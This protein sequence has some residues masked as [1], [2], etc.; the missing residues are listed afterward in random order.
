[1]DK[2]RYAK[3]EWLV[4][5]RNV[6]TGSTYDVTRMASRIELKSEWM[7]GAPGTLEMQLVAMPGNGMAWLTQARNG[8]DEKH[9][10]LVQF[11]VNGQGQFKGYITRVAQREGSIVKVT[12]RDQIFYLKSKDVLYTENMTASEIFTDICNR[13]SRMAHRVDAP[14]NAVLPPYYHGTDYTMFNAIKHAI[15]QAVV[16]ENK[17][18]LIRDEFGVLV[19]TE[20]TELLTD[21][22]LGDGEYALTYQ[23]ES[24]IEDGVYNHV[25]AFRA[26]PDLGA[27]DSW[28]WHD[29]GTVR[30]WGQLNLFFEVDKNMT[31]AEIIALTEKKLEFHNSPRETMSIT[32]LGHLNIHAGNGIGLNIGRIELQGNFWI[33]KCRHLY[34]NNY[35]TMDLEM[36]YV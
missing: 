14:A 3:Y 32:A 27:F 11:S 13:K 19:F 34:R 36:F 5:I 17:Q 18:Y 28:R 26:N 12:A 24:N 23:Y 15:D 31:D 21:L 30:R 9:G 4:L 6:N 22:R 33:T 8:L 10:H 1:M 16:A 29:S 2:L 35:H 20:I 7:T 25:T